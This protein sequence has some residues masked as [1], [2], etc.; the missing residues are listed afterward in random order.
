MEFKEYI[1]L[2][3]GEALDA[4]KKQGPRRD[5]DL[6][7]GILN[8]LFWQRSLPNR[9]VYD[10]LPALGQKYKDLHKDTLE[11]NLEYLSKIPQDQP[12]LKIS[13]ESQEIPVY[14]N[15]RATLDQKTINLPSKKGKPRNIYT[16]N[17][18]YIYNYYGRDMGITVICRAAVAC[19][20]YTND[21]MQCTDPSC[22]ICAANGK[23]TCWD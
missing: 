18:Y 15:L 7:T 10:I 5:M 14:S 4:D 13:R 16:L 21:P 2:K 19:T 11:D 1:K 17:D 9:T 6:L 12:F 3:I 20:N 22:K 8:A 23:K